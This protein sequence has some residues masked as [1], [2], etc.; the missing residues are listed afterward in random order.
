LGGDVGS[1][2]LVYMSP[3]LCLTMGRERV[4]LSGELSCGLELHQSTVSRLMGTLEH[5]DS[6]PPQSRSR[7]LLTGC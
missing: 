2:S 3:A 7:A 6:L 4:K 1:L 5:G